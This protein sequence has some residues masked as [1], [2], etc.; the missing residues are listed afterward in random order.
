MA[1][2]DRVAELIAIKERSGRRGGRFPDFSDVHKLKEAWD[3]WTEPKELF[4]SLLP[5]RLVTLIEVFCR[6]WVQK[7]IDRGSPYVEHAVDLKVDV[8]YDLT[9]ARSLHGKTISLGLLLSN[10]VSLS[11]IDA[12]SSVF[13]ILLKHDF[14]DWLSKV[15]S[16][17]SLKHDDDSAAPIVSDVQNLRRIL[18][19]T[20]NVRHVLVHEFPEKSPYAVEE[21]DE[22]IAAAGTFIDA[23]DEGFTQLLY[24]LY[25]ITQQ[26]MNRVAREESD[27]AYVELT[28]LADEVMKKCHAMQAERM[29]LIESG[30][31]QHSSF[32]VS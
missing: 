24:G 31:G 16:R 1:Q 14:F 27:A 4:G 26:E 13:S 30:M 11:K 9:L 22:M 15:R 18:G 10:S 29:Q 2:R 20:F 17:V 3:G 25:P 28:N 6:Y 7:L 32:S 12:I 5:A 19:R 23:A 21:I 8:K